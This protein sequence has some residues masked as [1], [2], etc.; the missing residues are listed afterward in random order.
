M[1]NTDRSALY[2]RAAGLGAVAGLRSMLPFALLAAAA[3]RVGGFA[4]GPFAADAGPPLGLLRSRGALLGLGLAAAGELVGDKLPFTPDR[5]APGPL[6][7]RLVI[8]ALAGAAL[9]R[10]AWRPPLTGAA[11]GAVA[12]GGGA[13][14]GFFA[15]RGLGRATKI[16]DPIWAVLEDAL[17][18]GLGFLAVRGPRAEG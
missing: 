14:A 7:G 2:A 15:R 12:A 11:L 17:A 10:D 6:G 16:P 9:Y 8:G 13:A 1:P 4:D 3:N 5:I 18:I